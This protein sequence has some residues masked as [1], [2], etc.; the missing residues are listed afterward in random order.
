MT[1]PVG[2][3]SVMPAPFLLTTSATIAL[4]FGDQSGLTTLTRWVICFVPNPSERI[5]KSW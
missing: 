1:L 3:K 5:V 2:D 4:P